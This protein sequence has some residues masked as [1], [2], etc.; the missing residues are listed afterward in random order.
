MDGLNLSRAR[1]SLFINKIFYFAAAMIIGVLL[2]VIVQMA[3]VHCAKQSGKKQTLDTYACHS[4]RNHF[5]LIS[6]LAGRGAGLAFMSSRGI[7]C[8]LDQDALADQR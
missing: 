5:L 2:T 6:T 8:V 3:I 7:H 1:R 4:K